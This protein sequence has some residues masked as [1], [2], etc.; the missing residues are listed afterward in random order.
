MRKMKI[1]ES[2]KVKT[3]GYGHDPIIYQY[4]S[5]A[6]LGIHNMGVSKNMGKPPNHPFVHRVF[7]YKPSILGVFPLFLETPNMITV[8]FLGFPAAS[9]W[10]LFGERLPK[11]LI[12]RSQNCVAYTG[13]GALPWV[14]GVE[15]L[16]EVEKKCPVL[17]RGMIGV[18]IWI[19]LVQKYI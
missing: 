2:L 3:F 12:R 9:L 4:C 7:P 10:C 15:I 5:P 14:E 6:Y 16:G 8:G 18:S 11:D 1:R 13:A 17:D 19:R